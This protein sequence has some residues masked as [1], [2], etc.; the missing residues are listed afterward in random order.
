M[1][2]WERIE[3]LVVLPVYALPLVQEAALV[4]GCEEDIDSVGEKLTLVSGKRG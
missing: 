4:F 1:Q 3:R 2:E